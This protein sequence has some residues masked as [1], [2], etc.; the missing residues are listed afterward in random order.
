IRAE[1]ATQTL[2]KPA[3]KTASARLPALTLMLACGASAQFPPPEPGTTGSARELAPIDLTG[4]WVAIVSEDWRWR[5]VTPARG[6][7]PSIPMNLDAQLL[8]EAWDPAADEAAGEACKAYGAPGLMRGPTRLRIA[9]RDDDTLELESDYGLQTR[10]FH[11][12]GAPPE[13]ANTW[14]GVSTAEW[15][16]AGESGFG[17]MKSVT[18]RLRPGYLRKNGVPYSDSTAFTE[19][20]DVHVQDN[21]DRYLVVTNTVED[22]VY[23]QLPWITAIHFKKEADRSKWYPTP[24]DAR[25]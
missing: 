23:L 3:A 1:T 7:F 21:G 4:Q 13:G 25:F 2:R 19:Y 6:D 24:C 16:V 22:P 17:S 20:W 12:D 5:M 11:F 18:T 8:A 14:Q 10:L 9:W 15:I